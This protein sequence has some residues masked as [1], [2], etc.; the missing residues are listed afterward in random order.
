MNQANKVD[1]RSVRTK[2]L[3]K[4]T[5]IDLLST[6]SLDKITVSEISQKSDISRG[7]FYIHYTDVYDLYEVTVKE[8]LEDLSALFDELYPRDGNN[9]SDF[10]M[11]ANALIKYVLDNMAL[12]SIFTKD[13]TDTKIL[14]K[15]NNIIIDKF[16]QLEKCDPTNLNYRTIV[17]FFGY[18]LIGT[19]ISWLNS[20]V[21]ISIEE[22]VNIISLEISHV[23]QIIIPESLNNNN[24]VS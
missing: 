1:K 14:A 10:S 6:K 16:L 11:L 19:I 21:T 2:R 20:S 9:T 4:S 24:K 15:I 5:F 22:L 12:L 13:G 3:I 18:G 17:S 8:A 23:R 7:T